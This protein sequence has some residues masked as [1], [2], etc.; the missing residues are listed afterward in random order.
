MGYNWNFWFL[1]RQMRAQKF[2]LKICIENEMTISLSVAETQKNALRSLFVGIKTATYIQYRKMLEWGSCCAQKN[3]LF[4]H[5]AAEH[6]KREKNFIDREKATEKYGV[7]ERE[8]KGKKHRRTNYEHAERREKQTANNINCWNEIFCF[9]LN[10]LC[11]LWMDPD[12]KCKSRV[13][14][15]VIRIER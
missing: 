14:Y 12:F 15:A 10:W 3:T 11:I 9:C 2:T 1:L 6:D 4:D 8:K 5:T 13:H 7:R